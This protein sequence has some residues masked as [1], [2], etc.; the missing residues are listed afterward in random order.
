[1]I[2][3]LVTILFIL[4]PFAF[5][6]C[7]QK[8]VKSA[9]EKP[10]I[11]EKVIDQDSAFCSKIINYILEESKNWPVDYTF[12][13]QDWKVADGKKPV[14]FNFVDG[15]TKE[16][17]YFAKDKDNPFSKVEINYYTFEDASI[18]RIILKDYREQAPQAVDTWEV[19]GRLIG[20]GFIKTPN[21]LYRQGATV[22]HIKCD[23]GVK[24]IVYK[25]LGKFEKDENIEEA[26]EASF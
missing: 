12:E 6:S 17:H 7:N 15:L 21:T 9:V 1:M 4:L 24:H 22:F 11:K 8:E 13:K 18:A 14:D 26:D 16:V 23:N 10:T 19:R 3:R 2:F 25:A 20:L 5:C